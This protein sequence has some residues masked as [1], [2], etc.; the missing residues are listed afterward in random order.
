[1]SIVSIYIF[2]KSTNCSLTKVILLLS[3]PGILVSRFSQ[4]EY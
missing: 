1:M 2:N 3:N 4:F